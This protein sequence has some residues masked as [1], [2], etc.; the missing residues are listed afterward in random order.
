MYYLSDGAYSKLFNDLKYVLEH[1]E[2]KECQSHY[3]S[4]NVASLNLSADVQLQPDRFYHFAF[5]RYFVSIVSGKSFRYQGY[6]LY[7]EN[8]SPAHI[9]R[10]VAMLQ[11]N[12]YKTD[13]A[14]KCFGLYPNLVDAIRAFSTLVH[15]IISES[16]EKFSEVDF[17][18]LALF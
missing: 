7:V 10:S 1:C 18:Q 2:H 13:F 12:L 14:D 9:S 16:F 17:L 11:T 15:T 8:Y 5:A 4:N 3:V 6:C